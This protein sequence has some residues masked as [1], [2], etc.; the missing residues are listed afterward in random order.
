MRKLVAALAVVWCVGAGPVHG[1]RAQSACVSA[2]VTMPSMGQIEFGTCAPL[3][4]SFTGHETM[5]DCQGVP[6]AG[7]GDCVTLSTDW[8]AP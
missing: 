6:P 3:P 1:A 5:S 7:V 4:G 2:S 8:W